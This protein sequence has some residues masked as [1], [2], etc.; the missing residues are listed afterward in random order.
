MTVV[1]AGV[2]RCALRLTAAGIT[3][4]GKSMTREEAITACKATQ[5][6]DIIVTGDARTGDWEDLQKAMLEA[7]LEWVEQ[8]AGGGGS[9]AAVPEPVGSGSDA[10]SAGAAGSTATTDSSGSAAPAPSI[11]AGVDIDAL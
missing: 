3:V 5:G 10:G 8:K 6:A 7:K 2:T 4:D 1:D 9:A 11:D